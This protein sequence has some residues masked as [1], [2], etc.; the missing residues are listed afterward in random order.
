M[1]FFENTKNKFALFGSLWDYLK[2]RKKWVLGPL[3]L[4]LVLF[5]VFV[6]VTAGSALAP[7]IYTL[8]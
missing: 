7:L 4:V 8:F 5:G 3:L 2:I 1:S 6:V